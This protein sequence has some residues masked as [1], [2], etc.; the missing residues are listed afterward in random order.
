MT[1]RVRDINVKYMTQPTVITLESFDAERGTESIFSGNTLSSGQPYYQVVVI[2]F[3]RINAYN[4][5]Y[6]FTAKITEPI[7]VYR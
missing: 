3:D 1:G 7:Y 6:S 5:S 2:V 4:M